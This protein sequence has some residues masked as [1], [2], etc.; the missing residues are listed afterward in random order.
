MDSI[1]EQIKK[2]KYKPKP[3]RMVEIPKP[4]DGIR[5]L[6]IPTIVDRIIID[7]EKFLDNVNQHKLMT[8]V[9]KII[10]DHDTE[11]L[12]NNS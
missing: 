2:R 7:F 12:T 3:L 8:L 4:S 6:G 10:K 1:K 5:K 9:D 11:S